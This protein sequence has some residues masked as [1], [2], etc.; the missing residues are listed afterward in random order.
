MSKFFHDH[1]TD[2]HDKDGHETDSQDTDG[3]D[4]EPVTILCRFLRKQPSEKCI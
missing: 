4:A 3:H 1:N 2:G